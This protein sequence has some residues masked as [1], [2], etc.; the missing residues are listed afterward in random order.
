MNG[1]A[2][3][4]DKAFL[5]VNVIKTNSIQVMSTSDFGDNYAEYEPLAEADS[6]LEAEELA[7]QFQ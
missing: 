6:Q 4:M 7:K 2:G 5:V 1:E 3:D